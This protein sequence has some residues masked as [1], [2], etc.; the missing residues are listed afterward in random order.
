MTGNAKNTVH[1][2]HCKQLQTIL[3]NFFLTKNLNKDCEL[4]TIVV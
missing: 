1:S 4:V 3:I 2:T